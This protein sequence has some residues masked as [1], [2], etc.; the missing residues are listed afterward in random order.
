MFSPPICK[1][2]FCTGQMVYASLCRYPRPW[3]IWQ[4]TAIKN[5]LR[6][7]NGDSIVGNWDQTSIGTRGNYLA[8]SIYSRIYAVCFLY[9]FARCH[10]APAKRSIHFMPLSE[11]GNSNIHIRTVESEDI[12][13]F[14][15][16]TRGSRKAVTPPRRWRDATFVENKEKGNVFLAK[17]YP[18][19]TLPSTHLFSTAG[20]IP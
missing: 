12:W 4:K 8:N 5:T 13:S 9:P 2:L 18:L 19:L 17:L 11:T 1:V 6:S 15:K 10:S 3:N 20:M 14:L 7:L 16:W